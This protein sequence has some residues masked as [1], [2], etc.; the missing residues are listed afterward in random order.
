MKIR[1]ELPEKFKDLEI[2]SEYKGFR[3]PILLQDEFGILETTPCKLT[4]V[5]KLGISSAKDKTAYF[6]AKLSAVQPD[7]KVLGEYVGALTKILVRDKYGECMCFP[8]SLLL[9]KKPTIQTA[10]NQTEYFIAK[11]REVHGDKYDYTKTKYEYSELNIVVIC[12]EHGRFRQEA[13]HHLAGCGCPKCANSGGGDEFIR[14]VK[15]LSGGFSFDFSKVEYI[16]IDT[17]VIIIEDGIASKVI[18]KV[19]L[20]KL[21]RGEWN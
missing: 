11:S 8:N 3:K 2:V 16:N 20:H 5:K 14:K 17:P 21:E 19:F 9:G 18:P 4:R 13:R 6:K 12:P 10:I 1:Y 7:L 15:S